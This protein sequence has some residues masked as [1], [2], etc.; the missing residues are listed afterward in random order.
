MKQR[1]SLAFHLHLI[2]SAGFLS[3]SLSWCVH[4]F[5]VGSLAV[6]WVSV[7]CV[8]GGFHMEFVS[9]HKA[10]AQKANTHLNIKKWAT[11]AQRERIAVQQVAVSSFHTISINFSLSLLY[12]YH[13]S[14]VLMCV[15]SFS[16]PWSG[17]HAFVTHYDGTLRNGFLHT[18]PKSH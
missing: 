13:F 9:L 3:L 18:D 15:V 16:E 12:K 8:V 1:S 2:A 14:A 11:G 6:P 7:W 17:P 4:I 10:K 5:A